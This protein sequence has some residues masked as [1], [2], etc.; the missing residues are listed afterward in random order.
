M[1]NVMSGVGAVILAAGKGTRMRSRFPKVT[2]HVGGR[3]MLEH[4]LRAANDALAPTVDSAE[5][6]SGDAEDHSPRFVVVVGHERDQ[7]QSALQWFP[8]QGELRFIVQEPQL[9]TGHAMRCAQRA[10]AESATSPQTILVLYGDTPLVRAETLR[11]L[12]AAHRR[13]GATLTFLTG[14]TDNPAEYGRVLRDGMGSVRG[15]VE[16]RYATPNELAITEVNSGIYCFD[17]AWLWS[18]LLALEP[19]DNGE[20]YLTDLVGAA[21]AEGRPISTA[22]VALEEA[23]GVNDR[24]Q[25]AE[26]EHILRERV[27][28]DLML[29]GVTIEDPATTYVEVGVVVGQDTVLRP[30]TRLQGNT[31][32]GAGC[33]IGPYSVIRDSTVGDECLVVSSWLEEAV[34]ESRSRIGPMSHLR[35]GAHLASGAHLGNFGEVKNATIGRD[36]QMHHFSYIG[37]ANVGAESNIGAGVITV[38]YDGKRKHHTEI[39]EHAF[40]GSDTMLRAPVTVGEGASTGTGSVVTRDV[41]AGALV[42]GMPARQMHRA[43]SAAADEATPPREEQA[44]QSHPPERSSDIHSDE[45]PSLDAP[46]DHADWGERE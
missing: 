27:L 16:K 14:L 8:S 35:P 44:M 37:D 45:P 22:S 36:V 38:N 13:A 20:Y 23:I 24:I 33:E 1:F 11:A 21:V 7:V 12:L 10:W 6:S 15:I 46:P 34:M 29:S 4:V 30:G 31:V 2:H 32:V 25:L 5:S 43:R 40:I 3:P 19:H 26:A 39:G 41:P 18:H 42:V 17:S 28:R 9:G